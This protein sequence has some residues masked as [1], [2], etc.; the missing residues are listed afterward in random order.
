LQTSQG[1][2]DGSALALARFTIARNS[3]LSMSS[4]W[5][6]TFPSRLLTTLH[7]MC[8]D[9]ISSVPNV[10][11]SVLE[12]FLTCDITASIVPISE[13]RAS[14]SVGITDFIR[15]N[16]TR[17]LK[18]LIGLHASIKSLWEFLFK[19]AP[20]INDAAFSIFVSMYQEHANFIESVICIELTAL[21]P[22]ISGAQFMEALGES[23]QNN[24]PC[25]TKKAEVR[26]Q[27][28]KWVAQVIVSDTS[29][30]LGKDFHR[31]ILK[32]CGIHEVEEDLKSVISKP[33]DVVISDDSLAG[34]TK[35]IAANQQAE[36][37]I[38]QASK[39]SED[40][41]SPAADCNPIC[42]S[43]T[44]DASSANRPQLTLVSAGEIGVDDCSTE[45]LQDLHIACFFQICSHKL[46]SVESWFSVTQTIIRAFKSLE[47]TSMSNFLL[48]TLFNVSVQAGQKAL[49]QVPEQSRCRLFETVTDAL[50]RFA[51]E[52]VQ[53]SASNWSHNE[54]LISCM[55]LLSPW[56]SCIRGLSFDHAPV[57]NC[58]IKQLGLFVVVLPL[59]CEVLLRLIYA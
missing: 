45:F 49:S 50:L 34:Q 47:D 26:W 32:L 30:V 40:Q 42:N 57:M 43:R 4:S 21:L 11:N 38:A 37:G 19:F 33:E 54:L 14:V 35:S 6:E 25:F 3:M 27:M 56:A 2:N 24:L 20:A 5:R 23:T 10:S 48:E 28:A 1:K 7:V 16:L 8:Q 18:L 39:G 31:F 46:L 12:H 41:T 22:S 29:P 15:G 44:N 9:T 36:I 59:Y 58:V 17:T 53:S 52:I 13:I 51:D 55:D